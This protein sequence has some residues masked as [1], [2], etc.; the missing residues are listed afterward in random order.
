[1]R[2]SVTF[3]HVAPSATDSESQ[4]A[5]LP[6]PGG[7]RR[8]RGAHLPSCRPGTPPSTAGPPP[9]RERPRPSAVRFQ[10]SRSGRQIRFKLRSQQGGSPVEPTVSSRTETA[11]PRAPAW[12]IRPWTMPWLDHGMTGSYCG[13]AA[14]SLAL[15]ER[16][17]AAARHTAGRAS[18]RRPQR[19]RRRFPPGPCVLPASTGRPGDGDFCS[20]RPRSPSSRAGRAGESGPTRTRAPVS[21][22]RPVRM[23]RDGT[24]AGPGPDS[25]TALRAAAQ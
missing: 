15:S 9:P 5:D 8:A 7:R 23:D 13:V 14:P 16:T 11:R 19:T 10:T 3:R 21:D 6:H 24:R 18:D 17:P 4:G 20:T 12:P 1:M 22:W 25:D 2:E